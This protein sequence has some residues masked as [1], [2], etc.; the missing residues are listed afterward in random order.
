MTH[1]L[2]QAA[3]AIN[4][5]IWLV[6]SSIAAGSGDAVCM[7]SPA[8]NGRMRSRWEPEWGSR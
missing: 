3:L 6:D 1:W 8:L 2:G 7:R 4:E 5:L